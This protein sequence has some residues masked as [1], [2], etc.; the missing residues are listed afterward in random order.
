M[1]LTFSLCLQGHFIHFFD[2]W[3]VFW[4]GDEHHDVVGAGVAGDDGYPGDERDDEF[5]VAEH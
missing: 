4:R 1:F 3:G 2:L 5:V